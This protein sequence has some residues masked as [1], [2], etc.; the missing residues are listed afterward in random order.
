M[1][2]VILHM[3]PPHISSE[4]E[5][6]FCLWHVAKLCTCS[7]K[8]TECWGISQN[9]PLNPLGKSRMTDNYDMVILTKI[10]ED[11]DENIL[12]MISDGK[13]TFIKTYL[14]ATT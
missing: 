13:T 10:S 6:R 1:I 5:C 3:D 12:V 2:H 11:L 9:Q 7:K 4:Q 8:Y 14:R